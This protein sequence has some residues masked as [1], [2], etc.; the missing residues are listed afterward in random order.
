MHK[1]AALA[2]ARAA[3]WYLT[4]FFTFDRIVRCVL[5]SDCSEK[6]AI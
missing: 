2:A 4:F 6:D 1:P 5:A 3:R